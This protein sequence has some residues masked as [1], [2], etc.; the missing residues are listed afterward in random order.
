[1]TEETQTE[2]QA[3]APTIN[4]SDVAAMLQ[5]IDTAAQRGAFRGEEMSAVGGVR[6]K[7]AAFIDFIRAAAEEAEGAATEEEE[8]AE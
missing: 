4:V 2:V 7:A 1:M 3:E 8:A 6:D 5:I